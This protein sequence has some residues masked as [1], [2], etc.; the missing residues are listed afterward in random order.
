MKQVIWTV[1][2][3]VVL[4]STFGHGSSVTCIFAQDCVLPCTSGYH[5]VIHWYKDDNVVHSFYQSKDQ[6][7]YQDT[8]YSGRTSLFNDQIPKGNLSLLLRGVRISDEGRYKCYTADKTSNKELFVKV[9]VKAP[10]KAADIKITDNT[11]SCSTSGVFPEPHI[12]WFIDDMPISASHSKTERDEQDLFSLNGTLDTRVQLNITYKC[13]VSFQ[14]LSQTYTASIRKEEVESY[15]GQNATIRCP[16]SDGDPEHYNL[17]LSF[18][19]STNVL[20]YISGASPPS[21]TTK[22]WRDTVVHLVERGTVTF[23]NVDREKHS[24]MYTCER[25]EHQSREL[26]LTRMQIEAD[27]SW[28]G[29]VVPIVAIAVIAV[30]ITVVIYLKYQRNKSQKCYQPGRVSDQN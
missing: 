11:I 23:Q 5:D 10:I 21:N 15:S 8:N 14:D 27:L 1:A 24:G 25:L 9:N 13:S 2:L 18:D 7:S 3:I 6:L 4:G 22:T 12:S 20:A 26:V 30:C 16:A 17:S 19:D 28:I 29:I